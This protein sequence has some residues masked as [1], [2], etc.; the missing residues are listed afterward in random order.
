MVS[1][2]SNVVDSSQNFD[3]WISDYFGTSLSEKPLESQN[4]YYK[5][6]RLWHSRKNSWV[7]SKEDMVHQAMGSSD[8]LL[9]S[10]KKLSK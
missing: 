7:N 1:V 4:N 3:S 9:S 8:L 5:C 10:S 2:V 6:D